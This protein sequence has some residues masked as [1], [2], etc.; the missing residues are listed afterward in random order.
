MNLNQKLIILYLVIVNYLLFATQ[1][2]KYK[3]LYLDLYLVIRFD[4]IFNVKKN[5]IKILLNKINHFFLYYYLL[6][7]HEV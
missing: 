6:I 5:I 2:I 7:D 4:V 3:L 1:K